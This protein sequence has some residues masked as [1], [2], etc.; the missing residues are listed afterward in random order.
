MSYLSHRDLKKVVMSEEDWLEEHKGHKIEDKVQE[1]ELG[2]GRA[3]KR[4]HCHKC[5]TCGH[6]H[7]FKM[8]TVERR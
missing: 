4:M 1:F 5:R 2:D 3:V 7:L 8:E 6:S